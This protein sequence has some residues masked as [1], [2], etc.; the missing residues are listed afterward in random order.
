MK[1]FFGDFFHEFSLPLGN[2]VLVFSIILLIILLS[3]IL[4]KRLKIPGII[5]LIISG[6]I[7]GPFGFNIIEKSSAVELFSTIGLLYIMFIAGLDLNIGQFKI[8]RNKSLAFGFFTF[9]FPL[10]IG[11]VLCFYVLGYGF[12]ASLLTASMF[13]THTLVA[14]PIVSKLGVTKN[15]AVA[16]TVGGT[17]LTDTAVLMVLAIIIGNSE[18]NLNQAFF[19]RLGITFTL[20]LLI[21]FFVIPRIARWFFQKLESEKHAHFIFVLAVMFFAAFLAELCGLEPIIGAFVAGLALNPIIPRSSALMNRL[22]FSGNALFIPFFLISV[23][24]IVDISVVTQGWTA[25]FVAAV[26]TIGALFGKWLAAFFTQVIFK[27]S[28]TQRKLIFGLSSS[29]AAATLAVIL[30]GYN[31]GILDENILNGTI[32]L[33]LITCIVA[34]FA[35]ERAAKKLVLTD[36]VYDSNIVKQHG[37]NELILIPVSNMNT[38]PK[39][40]ELSVLMKNKKSVNPITLLSVIPNNESAEQNMLKTREKLEV[41]VNQGAAAETPVSAITTIDYNSVGGIARITREIFADILILGWPGKSGLIDKIAGERVNNIIYTVDRNIFVCSIEKVLVSS[42]RIILVTPPIAEKENG[43]NLWSTKIFK[44]ASELSASVLH[45]GEHE[46]DKALRERMKKKQF[47]VKM[48]FKHF[49]EWE[50][51]LVLARHIT[52]EDLMV[53][54][55]ARKNSVSYIPYLDTILSKTEKYYPD[56]NRIVIYPQQVDLLNDKYEDLSGSPIT[57]GIEAIESIGKGIGKI[58]SKP[59]NEDENEPQS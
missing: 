29:H 25:A 2:P 51:F 15:E 4:L 37:S 48:D 26:L 17:I 32:I 47:N 49:E 28:K 42:K 30:V 3:P 55:S 40:L 16:I 13:A 35:T 5:G 59:D 38:V 24:M 9:V 57:K 58:F 50:D 8:N 54:V 6:V 1:E 36:E 11:F 34:S 31:A 52:S 41:Y 18:G 23:G 14:Y 45:F 27:Y 44:L 7:I 53:V 20:F 39:L 19:I 21:M 10:A 33:I 12:D 46:V 43:F 22:E 56:N